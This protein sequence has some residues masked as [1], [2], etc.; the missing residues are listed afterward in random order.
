MA[1]KD[2]LTFF[3]YHVACL[4]D[5]LGQKDQLAKW[6]ELPDGGQATPGKRGHA[7]FSEEI[8]GAT[9]ISVP[10]PFAV[11]S[12][13]RVPG[14]GFSLFLHRSPSGRVPRCLSAF[15]AVKPRPDKALRIP[16]RDPSASVGVT[17]SDA[18]PPR[19]RHSGTQAPRHSGT[20]GG[21]S[22]ILPL[23][24]FDSLP[25]TGSGQAA[26][27]GQASAISLAGLRPLP[28]PAALKAVPFRRCLS[29]VCAFL[30]VLR[31]LRVEGCAVCRSPGIRCPLR[32][33]RL[34]VEGCASPM[35]KTQGKSY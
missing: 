29:P 11:H 21:R 32:S 22:P 33:L 1:G 17:S 5:V 35:P 6:R 34:C 7:T 3:G 28:W 4:I 19:L 24:P 10:L 18:S 27:S 9:G 25:S 31:D 20:Q 14:S 13:F 2:D 26:R 23:R 16:R 12:A 15:S 30:C 8:P